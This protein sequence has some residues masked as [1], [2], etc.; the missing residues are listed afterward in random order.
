MLEDVEL[1]VDDSLHRDFCQ[2]CAKLGTTPD[3]CLEQIFAWVVKKPEIATAYLR[4]AMAEQREA[5]EE[6]RG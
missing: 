4:E 1:T 3:C 2:L 5:A 6:K